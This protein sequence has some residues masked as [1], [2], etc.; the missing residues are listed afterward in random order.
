MKPKSTLCNC[1]VFHPVKAGFLICLFL[2]ALW[3]AGQAQ[4]ATPPNRRPV[5]DEVFRQIADLFQYDLAMPLQATSLGS[6][7]YR[8]PYTIEKISYRSTHSETV[9]G[10]FAHPQDNTGKKFP[11][12][13]L[14][15][16][17]NSI[18]G[19]NESWSLDWLDVLARAGYCV[20]AIDNFGFGERLK[21]NEFESG[22]TLGPYETRD[23]VI[24]SVTDQRRGID[25]LLS[26]AEVDPARI[27]L[28]GGSRG[29]WIGALVA[30]LENRLKAV[31]LTVTAE[32]A[33]ATDDPD[34]RYRHSFNF[35]ARIHVPTLLV[36]ATQDKPARV[37]FDKELFRILPGPKKQ[38][39]IESEHYIPPKENHREILEYMSANMK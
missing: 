12:V 23:M 1:K 10:Y 11:A 28:L 15:H 25:Y 34:I 2:S 30:G 13:L 38:I 8:I 9:P 14:I 36:I 27:A 20:L 22:R 6:W 32:S 37:E 18:W 3:C 16:G 35:A 17:S 33:G 29:G 4:N 19:K 21:S 26:R 5:D 31:V 7:P 39:L 24:Q